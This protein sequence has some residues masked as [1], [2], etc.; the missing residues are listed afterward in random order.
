MRAGYRPARVSP[1]PPSYPSV[2]IPNDTKAWQLIA[3]RFWV[4]GT[5]PKSSGKF[6]EFWNETRI[7]AAV[8]TNLSFPL[9][10]SRAAPRPGHP[11]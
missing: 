10:S 6:R 3:E 9:P 4:V 8:N 7:S 2:R 11:P 5:W 1:S